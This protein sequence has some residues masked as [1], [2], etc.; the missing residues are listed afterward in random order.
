[1]Y[2]SHAETALGILREGTKACIRKF[3]YSNDAFSPEA[4]SLKD[5]YTSEN[6]IR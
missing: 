6:D 5:N 3:I 1:M 2:I 4:N